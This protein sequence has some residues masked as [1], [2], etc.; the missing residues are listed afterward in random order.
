MQQHNWL[1]LLCAAAV[2]CMMEQDLLL[3]L[4]KLVHSI[5]RHLKHI[6]AADAVGLLV[7][8]WWGT[9]TSLSLPLLLLLGG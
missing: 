8:C 6:Q 9:T 7:C 2:S 1:G 4:H 5:S 3:L